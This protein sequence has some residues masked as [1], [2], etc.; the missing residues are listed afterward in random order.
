MSHNKHTIIIIL[1]R[2][3]KLQ[4]NA[5]TYMCV[6]VVSEKTIVVKEKKTRELS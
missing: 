6:S 1:I 5:V 2:T 4:F 3:T